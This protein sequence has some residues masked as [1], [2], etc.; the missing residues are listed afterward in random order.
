MTLATLLDD[1]A[2]RLASLPR[3]LLHPP[4]QPAEQQWYED[5]LRALGE[6]GSVLERFGPGVR[7]ERL[8]A[9]RGE[10]GELPDDL[11]QWYRWRDGGARRDSFVQLL[12]L[13]NKLN[14]DLAR[15]I[16]GSDFRTGHGDRRDV[17]EGQY[18]PPPDRAFLVMESQSSYT[19][20]DCSPGDLG[21]VWSV[22]FPVGELARV[23]DSLT[24]LVEHCLR[25]LDLKWIRPN[26]VGEAELVPVEVLQSEGIELDE[27]ELYR[28]HTF[29]LLPRYIADG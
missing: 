26:D 1:Y 14:L 8:E 22:D 28:W 21:S 6:G 23:A 9:L 17:Y 25:L 18:L 29:G 10:F 3:P 15:S 2:R 7:P 20:V 24:G 11:E 13:G 19:I 12:P 4:S 16:W 27:W 5:R